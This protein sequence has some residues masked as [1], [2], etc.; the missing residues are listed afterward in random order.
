MPNRVAGL[1]ELLSRCL[2]D[3]RWGWS[4]GTWG[5]LAEF[6]LIADD[7]A[8]GV[9]PERL[10]ATSDRG[11]I[12]IERHPAERPIAFERPRSADRGWESGLVIALPRNVARLVP[13]RVLTEIGTDPHP[14]RPADG[15]GVLF[16]LGLGIAHMA[17]MIRVRDDGLAA[18]LRR[19]CGGSILESECS[20]M[21]V[22]KAA[23]PHRVFESRLGR[24]EV[25]QPIPSRAQRI[26]TPIGPH[27]HV[28][29]GLL[30]MGCAYDPD[31]LLPRGWLPCLQLH[32]PPE[33]LGSSFDPILARWG[34]PTYLKEKHRTVRA[35]EQG[36]GPEGHKVP[37]PDRGG[38]RITALRVA[39]RQLEARG[40]VPAPLLEAWRQRFDSG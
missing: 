6:Q 1:T 36:R 30:A 2:G 21:T 24:I 11:A 16:D 12:R 28:L 40:T 5:A 27:T 26:P 14:I 31:L 8:P 15:D 33:P 9:D 10:A 7:D 17:A 19:H 37:E 3:P 29:P 32:P 38:V 35:V 18:V 22:I 23:S 20:A 25:Y 34:M 13:R 39:L 4:V